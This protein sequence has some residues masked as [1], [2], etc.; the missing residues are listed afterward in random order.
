MFW[1]M[2][3]ASLGQ[4]SGLSLFSE[5]LFKMNDEDV[6]LPLRVLRDERWDN[7]CRSSAVVADS[8]QNV[9]HQGYG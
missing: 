6:G 5:K 7:N 3:T 1:F 8:A 9:R 4:H 2:P